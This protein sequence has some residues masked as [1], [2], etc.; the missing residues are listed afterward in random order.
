MKPVL[1]AFAILVG[2]L[3]VVAVGGLLYVLNTGVSARAQPGAIE[4]AIASRVRNLAIGRHARGL[5]NPVERT[6]EIMAAGRAHF[7]DHCASCH[8]NDGS[9]DTAMGRGLF[10][11]PPDMRLA[12]TQD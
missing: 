3:G 4:T 5:A 1:K 12:R 7:A 6:P 9:G 11:K 10:P 2:I 8:A